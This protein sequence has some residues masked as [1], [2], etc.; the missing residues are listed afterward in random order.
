MKVSDTGVGMT[1]E[2]M[3][4][5]FEP[6]FTTKTVGEGTGLGLA[7]VYGIVKQSGGTIWAYSELGEG[8]TF[9]I[10]L[11]R[12]DAVASPEIEPPREPSTLRGN[13][14]ILVVEDQEQVRKMAVQ[15]LRDYGYRVIEVMNPGEA[16]LQ[17]ERYAGPIHLMLTD[18]VMPGITG[19]ELAARVKPIRPAMQ[20]LFMSGYSEH[21][22]VRHRKLELS[23]AYLQKPFSG[24]SLAIAVREVLGAHRP[25]GTILVVDDEPGVRNLIRQILTGVGYEVLMAE[26]GREA[27]RII[28]GIAIDLMITD[29]AMAEQEGIETIRA[30]RRNH[31]QLRIIAMSGVFSS[32]LRAAGFFGAQASL[33]KPIERDELLRVVHHTML[34]NP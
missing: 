5:L 4:H 16:L 15:I 12:T 6:F 33:K 34:G 28:E 27:V 23:G 30:L 25:G 13:E 9:T 1:K 26:N 19:P 14:T 20:C 21:A 31:P 7:T 11:P 8:T 2:V 32:M 22:M 10:Y 24:E 17:C 29:L 3:S 18:V